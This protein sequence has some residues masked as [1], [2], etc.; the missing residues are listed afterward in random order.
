[1]SQR[2]GE[3]KEIALS[4][5]KGKFARTYDDFIRRESLLP[6]GLSELVNSAA[7]KEILEFGSGTG[8]VA[9]GLSLAG[10]DITAI[11]FSP[12]M[13]KTARLKARKHKVDVRFLT[14]DIVKV[15]LDRKFDLLICLGNTLPLITRLGDSR[16]LFKNCVRHLKPGG[17]AIFQMLNYDRI[18]RKKPTTFAVD[19]HDNLVRIKQYG[20]GAKLLDF[21][22]TLIDNSKIPP[23]VTTSKRK[24]RPWIRREIFA[25]LRDAGFKKVAGYGNYNRE[26]FSLLSKDLVIVAKT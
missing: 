18:L 14:G 8:A 10:Y 7:G 26:S 13:L 19:S 22:V 3:R 25:E 16:K 11:D 20:Y 15:R 9:I 6:E 4:E 12:D 1:M 5:L 24:I 2:V 17:T 23:V 21:I